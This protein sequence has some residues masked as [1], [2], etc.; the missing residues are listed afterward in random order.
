MS[1]SGQLYFE[2]S[3]ILRQ[4]KEQVFSLW[5]RCAVIDI[6]CCIAVHVMGSFSCQFVYRVIVPHG[7]VCALDSNKVQHPLESTS[8]GMTCSL[9]VCCMTLSLLSQDC[10]ANNQHQSLNAACLHTCSPQGSSHGSTYP[11]FSAHPT[12]LLLLP[13]LPS[14]NFSQPCNVYAVRSWMWRTITWHGGRR[15][16]SHSTSL[17]W[18]GPSPSAATPFCSTLEPRASCCTLRLA[19]S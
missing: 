11:F 14:P 2:V 6:K 13:P 8:T 18:M 19:S 1:S 9:P 15:M 16:I 3:C 17:A 7:F 10:V 5:S 12:P 4:G